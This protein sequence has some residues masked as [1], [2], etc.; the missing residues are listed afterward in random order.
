MPFMS[1]QPTFGCYGETHEGIGSSRSRLARTAR[2]MWR[3]RESG[4]TAPFYTIGPGRCGLC[5][6][7]S[8]DRTS[9]SGAG[10]RGRRSAA[11]FDDE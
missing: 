9:G 5:R 8:R 11:I 4:R 10:C 2:R 3:D 7:L 6:S 1:H